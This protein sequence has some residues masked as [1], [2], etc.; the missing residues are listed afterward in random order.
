MRAHSISASFL[1]LCQAAARRRPLAFSFIRSMTT[2]GQ[3]LNDEA[4]PA[5]IGYTP[6]LLSQRPSRGLK[7]IL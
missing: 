4:P 7:Q 6:L 5:S 2:V 3:Q 1:S